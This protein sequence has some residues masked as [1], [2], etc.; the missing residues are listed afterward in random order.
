MSELP[1]E[2]RERTDKLDAVGNT[3]AAIGKGFAI[4]SAALTAL[5]LFAAFMKTANVSAIDV[6]QPVIMAGLLIG[7]MLPFVFSALAMN[8]VGRA[9]MSMI[10]EVRRQ[11]RDIPELKAALGV[12]RKYN[13]DLTTATPE[14]MKIFHAADGVAEYQKCVAISTT[15][16]IR[17]MVLPGV[18]AIAVPVAIGFVGGAEML[19]GLLAGVTT[20]GVLMAIFQSNAG[21]AWDNAKKMIEEQGRK[22]T[23]AHKAAVVGDTVGDPFKD[24]SGPSLNILLKLM[25]VVALVIAPSIALDAERITAYIDDVQP[26]QTEISNEVNTEAEA[27]VNE[28]EVLEPSNVN[29]TPV[30]NE[31]EVVAMRNTNADANFR[32][33]EHSEV[34]IP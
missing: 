2:V 10:E 18:L 19:G 28:N 6:A 11:F 20:A 17:E 12:M 33:R 25:S 14:D 26:I 23:E 3:T 22:G 13:S 9:A 5:A 27:V 7:G 21:G 29:Y 15:A 31:N 30:E 32:P 1:K 34:A 24:T 4:A 8:A 16:S